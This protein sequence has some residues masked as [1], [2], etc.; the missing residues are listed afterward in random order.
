MVYSFREFCADC[1]RTLKADSGEKGRK[2]VQKH[3]EKILAHPEFIKEILGA[4][5]PVGRHII[6]HDKET[7][8]YVMVHVNKNAGHAAPHDHGPFWVIYGNATGYTDM[9]EYRRLDDG[10]QEGKAELEVSRKYRIE[11]GSTSLFDAGAIHAI[12]YPGNTMFVRLTGGDVESGKNLRFDLEN[13]TVEI[14]D[15]GKEARVTSRVG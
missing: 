11:P 5:P 3:F 10:S 6:H 13:N 7:D 15:R 12:E 9:T 14:Q 4:D 1:N 2:E 8:M